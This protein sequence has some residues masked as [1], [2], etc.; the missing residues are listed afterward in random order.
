MSDATN[1]LDVR[2]FA[3]P[4]PVL[5]A[6]TALIRGKGMGLSVHTDNATSRDNLVRLAKREARQ[7]EILDQGDGS[8][9]IA[10]SAKE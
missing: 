9:I 5:R 2:G 10:F 8:W 1:V 4:E 7:S 3:C 6:R